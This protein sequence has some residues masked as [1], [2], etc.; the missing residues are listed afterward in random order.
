[1]RI[2]RSEVMGMCF[3]V[4]DALK[5][6]DDID[7]PEQVTIH[8]EL[9]H[10]E[11]V[12]FQLDARGFRQVDE[13]QRSGLPETETVLVTA[14][15][16]SDLERS[17][18]EAAGKT[19]VDTTCPLVT[20]VHRAAKALHDQGYHV[21]VI[22]KPGHVEVRGI[23]DDLD[24]FDV[25]GSRDEARDFGKKR[26]GIVCQTTTPPRRARSIREAIEA[27][28]PNAEIRFVDT[29]CRPTKDHQRALDRLL[30]EVDA[31]VVVGG[32]NSNNTR[33]LAATCRSRGVSAYHVQG[34]EDLDPSWFACVEVVGLT[35][36]TS[37]LDET[38]EEV[39]HALASLPSYYES[40]VLA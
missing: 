21:L 1:M 40:G 5:I 13:R 7:Q 25:V 28:N 18:L 23:V 9:V 30:E 38:I 32:A 8:G 39:E 34:P 29:V 33:E 31:V 12:L 35:A 22:G 36:G 19:L 3:G 11:V 2:V 14:H 16:I 10:N 17:R 4:R 26:L 24:R 15:G 37:T 27:R 6:L 20:R